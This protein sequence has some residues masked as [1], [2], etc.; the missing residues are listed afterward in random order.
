MGTSPT[1]VELHLP[2][3]VPLAV[4]PLLAFLA[5]HA[6]PGVER[7]NGP[8]RVHTRLVPAPHGP[9]LVRVAFP[10]A[11]GDHVDLTCE[12]AHPDDVAHVVARVRS[13]LD[14]DTDTTGAEELLAADP[15]LAPAV[16]ARPGLRVPGSVDGTETALLAVLGQQVSLAAARTF[17]ARLLDAFGTVGPGGLRWLPDPAV[18]ATAGPEQ[19]QR[20][21]G[22]THARARTL[23]VVAAAAAD[24]LSLDACPG[25]PD[26][27]AATRRALLALPGI[28]PWTADYVGL[29]CLRDP[30]AF[31]PGDLVLRRVLGV[32]TPRE[33]DRLAEPWRPYRGYALLHL[34]TG[35][36]FV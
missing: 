12:A 14:L 36:V 7:H 15:V 2:H 16:A 29:R 4:E 35:A 6:V 1:V 22:V 13:W 31:L 8:A 30:D 28:G 19:L 33:A 9:A 21:T 34:W 10:A 25:D 20:A 23:H 27:R 32:R 11:G 18:L 3:P 24:G 26:S 5:A 17:A